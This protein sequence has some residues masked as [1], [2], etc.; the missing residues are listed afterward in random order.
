MASELLP[1]LA[2][3]L[4]GDVGR[5]G[6]DQLD[7]HSLGVLRVLRAFAEARQPALR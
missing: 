5:E 2:H 1:D 7:G 4:E 3:H 6:L